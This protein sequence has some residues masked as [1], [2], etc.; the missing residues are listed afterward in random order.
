MSARAVSS[1]TIAFGLVSI[2]VK[3]YA[4]AQ[5]KAVRFNLLHA[6]D[7]SRLQQH[8][9]CRGCGERV[10]RDQTVKGFEV[11]RGRYLVMTEGE[12]EALQRR[13]EPTIEVEAFVPLDQVDPVYLDQANLLGPDRGGAKAYRLLRQVLAATGTGA[14]ARFSTRGR[15]KL[16][17]LRATSAGL[18]LHSLHYADEVRGFADLDLGDGVE[19][20]DSEV[21]LAHELV[22][23]L[24]R[25]SFDPER[26]EDGYRR[27]VLAAIEA[28]L[29][30]EEV[31]PRCAEAEP[32]ILDLVEALKRSLAQ[33][34]APARTRAKRSARK[35]TRARSPKT[36]RKVAAT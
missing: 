26:Y 32:P 19:L 31:A 34:P 24:S 20:K 18:V 10:E 15:E 6:A 27:D 25:E 16:V 8:Y 36:R 1:A 2:P 12:L 29:A 21:E 7:R 28:K 23:K 4:A 33:K 3:L 9:S 35:G 22:A 30:G 13:R 17:L 14:I 11:A 5:S